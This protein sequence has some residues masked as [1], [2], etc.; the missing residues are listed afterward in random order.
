MAKYEI[1]QRLNTGGTSAT[2]QEIRNCILIMI[3]NSFFSWMKK[4]C[5]LECFQNCISL[6]DRQQL[7]AFDMEL[8]TR[9]IV[10]S[11][12]KKEDLKKID[13]LSS[14]LTDNLVSIANDKSFNR[15]DF[16]RVF[17]SAFMYLSD[18]LG[19]DSFKKYNDKN[20]RYQGATSIS[21]FEIV[22]TGLGY[23]LLKGG[24]LPNKEDFLDKHKRI[25]YDNEV[26][27]Y[28]MPGVRASTRLPKT[29]SFGRKWIK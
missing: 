18:V 16:E 3:N 17:Q 11:K 22:G 25:M 9:F 29:I 15:K 20:N 4:L 6:S 8:L 2:D 10:F 23:H 13:E 21:A 26:K 1:F 5:E 12:C 14:F 24:K 7:E 19:E 28:I 27:R